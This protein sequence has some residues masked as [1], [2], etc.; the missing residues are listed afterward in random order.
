EN[1][2]RRGP[3][4][5]GEPH[6]LPN[7]PVV[8]VSWYEALAFVRWLSGHARPWLPAG[9]EVRLPSEAEWEKAGRGGAE[10]PKEWVTSRLSAGL[11]AAPGVERQEN[12]EP[13][14]TY[15]WGEEITPNMANYDDTGIG[16]TSAIGCFPLGAGPYGVE[17]L[18]GNVWEWTRSLWGENY[19]Y[20]G[21]VQGRA[22]REN[23]AAGPNEGRVIRGS[24]YYGNR[25]G[26]RCAYRSRLHPY[27]FVGYSGFR[28]VVSPL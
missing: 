5:Y 1:T 9:W 13:R 6:N 26:V 25:T 28:V 14:R 23:L 15:P 10:I 22:S 16:T 2:W 20:P 12:R 27:D 3:D 21:D 4:A 11:A 17:E 7:H 24:A 19:P 8:G 18:S